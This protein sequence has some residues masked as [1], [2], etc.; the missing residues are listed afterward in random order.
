MEKIMKH[1]TKYFKISVE[2]I[3]LLTGETYEGV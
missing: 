3:H 1:I 2:L